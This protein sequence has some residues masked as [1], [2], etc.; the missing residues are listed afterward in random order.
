VARPRTSAWAAVAALALLAT[1]PGQVSAAAFWGTAAVLALAA[2][3]STLMAAHQRATA[4]AWAG[5]HAPLVPATTREARARLTR[6]RLVRCVVGVLLVLVGIVGAVV[7][8]TDSRATDAFRATATTATGTVVAVTDDDLSATV[9]LADGVRVDLPLQSLSPG[10]GDRVEIRLDPASGRAERVDDVFDPTGAL[11]PSAGGLLA[12]LTLLLGEVRRRRELRALL[13][14][15]GPPLRLV[16]D[17]SPA[18]RGVLLS[19]VDDPRPFA[20]LPRP[21]P[22]W[23]DADRRRPGHDDPDADQADEDERL[24][25]EAARLAQP[26]EGEVAAPSSPCVR[27]ST[28]P[29]VVVGLRQDGS[30]A[31]VAGPDG[32]WLVGDGPVRSPA[33][34]VDTLRGPRPVVSAR[35][36][37]TVAAVDDLP[38]LLGG[39]TAPGGDRHAWQQGRLRVDR[40]ASAV[41]RTVAERTGAWLPLL[42]LG[43][44]FL[45]TQWLAPHISAFRLVTWTAGMMSIGAFWR[46]RARAQLVPRRSGLVVTGLLVDTWAPWSRVDRVLSRSDALVIRTIGDPP[47]PAHAMTRADTDADAVAF[48]C[49]VSEEALPLVRGTRDPEEARLRI[50]SAR[51]GAEG[52]TS[53]GRITS[54]PAVSLV[55]GLA[56]GAVA[57][58]G[59]LAG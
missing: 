59:W 41:I 4:S 5:A 37:R 1:H 36:L 34:I 43:P 28:T 29:V 12:G 13:H 2:T 26:V 56:W 19:T 51:D 10:I 18:Q 15:G 47:D 9:E 8:V 38:G 53:G 50:E 32:D 21:A 25:A 17:W 58:T 44:L 46:H 45:L 35:D 57:V 39:R 27:W 16:A 42:L 23:T 52:P 24:L 48:L 7:F 40:R 31:A 20:L 54:R 55:V 6:P 33:G 11:I 14:D 22:G 3:G 30:P 49:P